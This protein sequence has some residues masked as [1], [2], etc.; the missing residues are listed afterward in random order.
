MKV[1]TEPLVFDFPTD[2]KMVKSFWNNYHF[3]LRI[4]DYEGN[5]DLCWKKSLKKR[6][7]ILRDD[8]QKGDWWEQMEKEDGE[9]VF[10]R[11]KYTVT[12]L[13]RMAKEM[14]KQEIL[15]LED[16]EY[17]CSCFS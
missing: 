10:D 9:Y 5:C 3:D 12:Q 4:N 2:K 7:M 11:D 15:N 16:E 17:F 1:N 13:K 14:T 8:P 6:L